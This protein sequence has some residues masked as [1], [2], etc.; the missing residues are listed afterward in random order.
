[1]ADITFTA[2]DVRPLPGYRSRR[3]E[4]GDTIYTGEGVYIDSNGDG[5]S[6]AAGDSLTACAY[7]ICAAVQ[8]DGG[9]TVAADGVMMDVVYSGAVTGFSSMTPGLPVFVSATA[10]LLTQDTPAAGSY[11]FMIGI[12]ESAS[13]ILVNPSY[14][15]PLVVKA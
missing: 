3:I 1:M 8:V 11:V 5:K 4:S 9:G 7:G 14:A 13:I 15:T 2:S 10:G 12:A 6:T